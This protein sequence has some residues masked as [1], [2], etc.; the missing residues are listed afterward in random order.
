M[1]VVICLLLYRFLMVVVVFNLYDSD[2][3][4]IIAFVHIACIY[5]K[6]KSYNVLYILYFM[7]KKLFPLSWIFLLGSRVN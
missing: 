5:K 4:R 2:C 3:Y 7:I 1:D 6:G